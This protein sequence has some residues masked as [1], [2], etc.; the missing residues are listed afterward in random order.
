MARRVDHNQH[1]GQMI[2]NVGI[3]EPHDSKPQAPEHRVALGVCLNL[4]DVVSAIDFHHHAGLDATEVDDEPCEDML[5]SE[6]KTAEPVVAEGS[7]KP[8]FGR[9]RLTP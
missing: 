6:V 9:R 1:L 2:Q 3:A 8:L 7:P 4:I 5:A